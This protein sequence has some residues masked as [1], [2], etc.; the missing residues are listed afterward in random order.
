MRGERDFRMAFVSILL[1]LMAYSGLSF[2]QEEV[3]PDPG[4]DAQ[5]DI[6][7][8]QIQWLWGE[9]VSVEP[10][11]GRMLVRFTD[12]DTSSEREIAVLGDADTKYEGVKSMYEIKPSDTVNIDYIITADGRNIARDVSVEVASEGQP[13]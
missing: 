11:A 8:S 12:Y 10:E 7:V 2:A 13:Q 3:I 4:E 1:C 6:V 9:V 5:G